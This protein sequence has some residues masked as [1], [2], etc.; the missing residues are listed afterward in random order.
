MKA[1]K[2]RRQSMKCA[3]CLGLGAM[4]TCF[5][6]V[7]CVFSEA[8]VSSSTDN[9]QQSFASLC[10][11]FL[12]TRQARQAASDGGKH[13]RLLVKPALPDA[14]RGSAPVIRL[15]PLYKKFS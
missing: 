3:L 9:S 4:P 1:T 5:A 13:T 7:S 6:P 15:W 14:G 12:P 8:R 10:I 2:H 11:S